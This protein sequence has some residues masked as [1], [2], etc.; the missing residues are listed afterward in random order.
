MK[1]TRLV[2][3]TL[4]GISLGTAALSMTKTECE[5][6]HGTWKRIIGDMGICTQSI[7]MANQPKGIEIPLTAE[8]CKKQHGQVSNDGKLCLTNT[9]GISKT[10]DVKQTN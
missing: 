6:A 2:M 4:L 3:L 5:G 1:N 10:A 8:E 7:S 9:K